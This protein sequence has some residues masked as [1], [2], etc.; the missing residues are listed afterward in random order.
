[1]NTL[2]LK[3]GLLFFCLSIIFFSQ[4]KLSLIEVLTNSLLIFILST[5]IM[6]IG[7][8]IFLKTLENSNENDQNT[9][10]NILG[11]NNE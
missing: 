8:F 11:N 7:F 9:K 1:M 2:V 5:I 3:I 4:R 10:T 6:T